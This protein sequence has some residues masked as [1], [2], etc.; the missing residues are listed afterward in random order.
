M[1]RD[2][3]TSDPLPIRPGLR[4]FCIALRDKGPNATGLRYVTHI[5]Y[6]DEQGGYSGGDYC[7]NLR[8]AEDSFEQRVKDRS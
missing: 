3:R 7:H 4:P 5:K 6:L 2:L 1:I 8:A